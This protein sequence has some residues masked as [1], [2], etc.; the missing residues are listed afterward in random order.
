MY[1][2]SSRKIWAVSVI[3]KKPPKPAKIRPMWSPCMP[4]TELQLLF[5][6]IGS[7]GI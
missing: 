5:P 4:E 3:E 1:L 7:I 6:G 2:K